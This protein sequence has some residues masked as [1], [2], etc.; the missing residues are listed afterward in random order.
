M[1]N[2]NIEQSPEPTPEKLIPHEVTEE[3]LHAA[4]GSVAGEFDKVNTAIT[5]GNADIVPTPTTK[6]PPT[7][8]EMVAALDARDAS[9]AKK[10]DS[11]DLWADFDA[12]D[13]DKP[14]TKE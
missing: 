13:P 14:A 2:P 12:S 7:I 10:P 9:K 8:A 5:N 6:E 11:K 1:S 3:E 4:L